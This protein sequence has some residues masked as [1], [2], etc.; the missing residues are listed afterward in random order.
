[1]PLF[2]YSFIFAVILSQGSLRMFAHIAPGMNAQGVTSPLGLMEIVFVPAEQ[3]CS[4]LKIEIF[5]SGSVDWRW[6]M[7]FRAVFCCLGVRWRFVCLAMPW[8]FRV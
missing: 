4:Q 2:W 7:V 1:M 5:M 6:F 3:F 8:G